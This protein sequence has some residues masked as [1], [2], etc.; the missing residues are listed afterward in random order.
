MYNPS[1]LLL[2]RWESGFTFC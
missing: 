2:D 1:F